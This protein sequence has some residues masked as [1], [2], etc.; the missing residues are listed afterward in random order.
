MNPSSH[1]LLDSLVHQLS[2]PIP[3]AFAVLQCG[4]VDLPLIQATL[5]N[6]SE[7][8][9][10]P[11]KQHVISH[12]HRSLSQQTRALQHLEHTQAVSRHCGS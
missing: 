11:R 1:D 5:A 6:V 3:D 4:P 9:W 10:S 7:E 2:H 8:L 12:D